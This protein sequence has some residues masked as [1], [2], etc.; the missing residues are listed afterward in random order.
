MFEY[1]SSLVGSTNCKVARGALDEIP[2]YD[3][4]DGPGKSSSIG[5]TVVADVVGM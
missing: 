1:S 2:L 3:S 5:F 4:Q